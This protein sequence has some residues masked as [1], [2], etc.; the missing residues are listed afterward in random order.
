MHRR[1]CILLVVLALTTA[2]TGAQLIDDIEASGKQGVAEFRMQFSMP[3]RYLRHFPEERGE[4]LKVYLQAFPRD[5]VES[6]DLQTYKRVPSVPGIPPFTLLY[7]TVR[8]C[9]AVPD[10]VC[11]DIQFSRPVNFRLRPGED[12]RSLVLVVLPDAGTTP[13]PD[14]TKKR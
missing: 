8:S 6:A 14:K 13:A 5:G 9:Y 3:V 7:T 4:L 11:L 2:N 1:K 10:P 12:G